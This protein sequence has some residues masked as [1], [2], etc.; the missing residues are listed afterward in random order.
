MNLTVSPS[1]LGD[2]APNI[3]AA[4]GSVAAAG[5]GNVILKAGRYLVQSQIVVQTN[6]CLF[7]TGKVAYVWANPGRISGGSIIEVH[8]GSGG[9]SANH[10]DSAAVILRS[11]A[12][13]ENV[14]FDYPDQLPDLASPIEWGSTVQ[15]CDPVYGNLN[16]RI[17]DCYFFKSYF[18]IDARGSLGGNLSSANLRISGC[19]GS[20]L[21]IGIAADFIADW[22]TIEDCNFNAG[23]INPYNPKCGLIDW[24]SRYGQAVFLGGCDWVVLDGI[25]AWGYGT[26]CSIIGGSGYA[27]SGPY[28]FDGCQFDA[29]W[30]GVNIG[31]TVEQVV[32]ITNCNFASFRATDSARGA[33]V[34]VSNGVQLKSGLQFTNN[35]IFGPSNNVFWAGQQNQLICNVMVSNNIANV[36]PSGDIAIVISNGQN[37]QVFGNV[38][39]NFNNLVSL[40]SSTNVVTEWNQT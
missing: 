39:K 28:C 2:D 24:V 1:G 11:G 18:A 26:G 21:S 30:S 16:Q 27:G 5:G 25:Q 7:G 9:N 17:A 35:Y 6:V 40:G 15:I 3:N 10:S 37:V 22:A 36:T 32:K 31:G 4:I 12:A 20:P 8:W 19:V 34:S 38:F 23:Q 33:S 13:I 14:G 29:C